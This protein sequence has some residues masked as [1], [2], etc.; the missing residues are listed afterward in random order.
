MSSNLIKHVEDSVKAADQ[1]LSSLPKEALYIN[2]MSSDKT[3]HLINNL[4]SQAHKYLEIGTWRGSTLIAA[5]LNTPL[6]VA[7][8]ID[9]FSQFTLPHPVFGMWLYCNH[10]TPPE[11]KQYWQ[12]Q[13][14]PSDELKRNLEY[15]NI[16][17]I[18]ML[19]GSCFSKDMI[20]SV[21]AIG[22]FDL[23]FND[24][25]HKYISQKQTMVDYARVLT[26][27]SIV[28]VD[29]WNAT[30]V[31]DGTVAGLE[32]AKLKVLHRVDL[33]SSGNCDLASWWNGIGIFVVQK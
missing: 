15:F 29:D 2:G 10:N 4:A 8:G 1:G 25:D 14:H 19:E 6:Q 28:V 33:F 20:D 17:G 32:E 16:D 22:P 23:F 26:E 12:T 31:R 11:L 13:M 27:E 9:D 30:E 7:V 3:R 21:D 18:Q 24:G 5:R